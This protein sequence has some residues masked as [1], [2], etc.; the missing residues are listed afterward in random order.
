VVAAIERAFQDVW[1]VLYAHLS[2]D[3]GDA[4]KEQSI[5]LSQ[6]L[7]ALAADGITDPRELRRKAL[8]AMVLTPR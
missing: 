8:E 3:G 4:V 6:T 1:A 7:V 5:A 2:L